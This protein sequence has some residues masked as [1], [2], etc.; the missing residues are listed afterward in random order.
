MLIDHGAINILRLK[1]LTKSMQS[2]TLTIITDSFD[3]EETSHPAYAG[4]YF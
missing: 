2:F 4:E 3:M 1:Q